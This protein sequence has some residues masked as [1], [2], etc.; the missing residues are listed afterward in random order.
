MPV[1]TRAHRKQLQRWLAFGIAVLLAVAPFAHP[2]SPLDL[3]AA[4]A[5]ES[6]ASFDDDAASQP[7]PALRPAPP[8]SLGILSRL[9][10]L[11]TALGLP[12]AKPPLLRPSA[13]EA[14]L[15]VIQT[16]T[17]FGGDIIPAFHRSSVGTARTPTGPPS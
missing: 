7:A 10:G 2:S 1:G 3:V 8:S 15:A 11:E 17:A 6:V 4:A 9:S 14:P 13:P 16:A 5:A 12:P